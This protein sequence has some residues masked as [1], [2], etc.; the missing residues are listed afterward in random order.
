MAA[1]AIEVA[2]QA[3][4]DPLAAIEYCYA[5]DGGPGQAM[6]H[7]LSTTSCCVSRP[8]LVYSHQAP[9]RN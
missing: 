1:S 4:V 6:P 9:G 3:A 5:Q 2:G 8:R 7:G